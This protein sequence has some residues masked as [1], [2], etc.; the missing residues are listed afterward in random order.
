[1]LIS[2]ITSQH[3]LVPVRVC[4]CVRARACVRLTTLF[5]DMM[6]KN[7]LSVSFAHFPKCLTLTAVYDCM[8]L[9]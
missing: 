8:T 1:M 9:C 3:T 2:V 7:H 4:M 5:K 6:H